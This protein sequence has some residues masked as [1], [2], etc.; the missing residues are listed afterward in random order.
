MVAIFKFSRRHLQSKYHFEQLCSNPGCSIFAFQDEMDQAESTA[1]LF[2]S[3]KAFL[4][5]LSSDQPITVSPKTCQRI[6]ACLI[7]AIREQLNSKQPGVN[8]IPYL[9]IPRLNRRL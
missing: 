1:F 7:K 5:V 2:S 6:T 9:P 4:V 8:F 3:W